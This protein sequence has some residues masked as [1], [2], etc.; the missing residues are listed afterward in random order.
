MLTAYYSRGCDSKTLFQDLRAASSPSFDEHINRYDVIHLD[1]AYFL[2]QI[3]D[4]LKAVSLIQSCV[5]DELNQIYPEILSGK[6]RSLPFSLSKIHN[7]TN[8]GFVI[9]IDEWDLPKTPLLYSV[10]AHTRAG[11][12]VAP[13]ILG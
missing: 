10:M 11:S 13:S 1:I 12:P 8:A 4:S 5:I 7:K 2:V 3:K 6:D 9:I